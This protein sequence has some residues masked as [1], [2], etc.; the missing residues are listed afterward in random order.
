M[1]AGAFLFS[2][3]NFEKFFKVVK[4]L[5]LWGL[6]LLRTTARGGEMRVTAD[7]R[8][9]AILEALCVRRHETRENLA[10]E[11]GVSKS[12]RSGTYATVTLKI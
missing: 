3:K 12:T 7:E 5:R 6:D 9:R 4:N 1:F 11:F 2:K 10:F 8:R